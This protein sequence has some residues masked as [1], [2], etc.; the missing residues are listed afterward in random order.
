M[1]GAKPRLYTG[2]EIAP[3]S[4]ELSSATTPVAAFTVRSP[5]AMR[6]SLR[7]TYGHVSGFGR[8]GLKVGSPQYDPICAQYT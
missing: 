3:Q 4:A 2:Y 7:F 8:H 6:L 5:R 1:W